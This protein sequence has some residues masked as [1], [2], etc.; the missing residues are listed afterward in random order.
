M[1]KITEQQNSLSY[2]M[3]NMSVFEIL[4]MMN[5]EDALI[6]SAINKKLNKI[7]LLINDVVKKIKQNGRLFYL[8][9]GTSGRLGVLDASECP[10]TFSTNPKLVQGI[11]AGGP[12]ALYKSVEGAED[13]LEEGRKIITKNKIK[14]NDIIIGISA[15]G[16]AP[17]V[18]SA[19]KEAY[20]CGAMTSLITFNEINVKKYIK[21]II[22][23]I[24]G[25]ELISGST[26][27]KAG[28]AT[29]MILNMISTSTMI[30]L[31]KTYQNYMVDL[32]VSNKKL[33]DRGLNI[34]TKI[35]G[36]NKNDSEILLNKAN[37]EVK[38][39]LAM[40]KLNCNYIDARKKLNIVNGN[41]AMIL[42]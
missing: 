16:S 35:S 1:D 8:G 41:L 7:E 11:I 20:D 36:L 19:L 38:T 25:P 13:S 14:E 17:Y 40:N 29:K 33:L 27:L 39:A 10:P 30:K 15:N 2:K 34:I 31:N 42:D 24:T 6:A 9:C 4:L 23:I 22:S 21:H 5:K 3:N 37:G 28:T 26:R 32:K 18:L 12:Q